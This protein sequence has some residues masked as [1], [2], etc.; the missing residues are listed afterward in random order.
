MPG[1]RPDIVGAADIVEEVIRIHGLDKV[2]SV[3]LPRADGVEEIYAPGE[4]GDKVLA[5]RT[6]NGI[7]LPQGTWD[8]LKAEADKLGIAMPDTL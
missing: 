5:E 2:A 4:R 7:P 8:R 6:A 3:G 1:W